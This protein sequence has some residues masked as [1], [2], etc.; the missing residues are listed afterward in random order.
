MTLHE[1]AQPTAFI[2][3]NFAFSQDN[4]TL[5]AGFLGQEKMVKLFD[6]AS[7]KSIATVDVLAGIPSNV[8]I[9]NC[10]ALS[11][12]GKLLV[13]GINNAESRLFDV[14]SGKVLA[15]LAKDAV[16]NA[17]FSHDGR[18]LAVGTAD[19]KVT[20]WEITRDKELSQKR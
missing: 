1:Q 4:K 7:E 13:A 11:P 19:G 20:L 12:D 15:T 6:V 9:L 10:L 18:L 3:G 5:A 16:L 8:P 17:V 14:A 2:T